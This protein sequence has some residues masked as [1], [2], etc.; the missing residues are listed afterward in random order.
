LSNGDDGVAPGTN[1]SSAA[2]SKKGSATDTSS[3]SGAM[4]FSALLLIAITGTI[5][6]GA[7][8]MH[9]KRKEASSQNVPEDVSK[10]EISSLIQK[11]NDQEV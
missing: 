11:E 2:T 6:L 9:S 8:H 4:V 7:F 10:E 1:A 3:S 5:L